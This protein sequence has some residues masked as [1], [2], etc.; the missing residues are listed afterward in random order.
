MLLYFSSRQ[1]K[2]AKG[3]GIGMTLSQKI[4]HLH[5][6]NIAVHS[7]QGK[8]TLFVVELPHV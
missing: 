5:G 8:G 4:I 1:K 3:H 7:E 6:G 2:G